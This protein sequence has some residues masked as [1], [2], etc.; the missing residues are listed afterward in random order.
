MNYSLRILLPFLL[1]LLS[2]KNELF[3]LNRVY[4]RSDVLDR[5]YFA[6][7]NPRNI[8]ALTGETVTL[9]CTVK[10]RGNQTVSWIRRRDLAILT[11]NTFVYTTDSRFS[12]IHIPD[13]NNWDLRIKPVSDRE[14]GV[15]ECQVNT[16]PK[17]NFPIHLEVISDSDAMNE[18]GYKIVNRFDGKVPRAKIVGPSEGVLQVVKGSTISLTCTVNLQ[19]SLILWYHNSTVINSDFTRGGINLENEKT[20]E[21]TTSRLLL[22][23]ASF[24]DSGNYTCVSASQSSDSHI[25]ILTAMPDSIMVQVVKL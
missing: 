23:R 21:G 5:P 14:T 16:E 20:S 18:G 4:A 7:D 2:C 24:R 1:L 3:C 15:Y 25:P 12:V 11:S 8:T 6:S 9:K 10:N 17:I 13:S 19:A 22:T